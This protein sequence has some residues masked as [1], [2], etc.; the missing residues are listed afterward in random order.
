MGCPFFK[1]IVKPMRQQFLFLFLLCFSLSSAAQ[2]LTLVELNCE[3]LFDTRHDEGKQDAEFLPEAG[4][5][6]TPRRYWR[7]VNNLAQEII[8][9]GDAMQL[10]DVVALCE[11]ENDTCLRDL[12][13][14]SLLRN[15]GYEYLM[16][17]S[18]DERGLD[19]ALLY[20]PASFAPVCYDELHVPT[21][22]GMR[23]TR[24]VLHVAGRIITGDTLH[25]FV[26]HAPSRYG[27]EVASRPFRL[28]VARVLCEAV[29]DLRRHSPDARIVIAGDFNDYFDSPALQQLEQHQLLNVGRQ[30]KGRHGALATY[31]YQGEWRS[32]DHVFVSPSLLAHVAAALI[33]DEPFLL[34]DDERYGGVKPRRTYSGFNYRPA[35]SD[36]L[37]LVVRF[38]F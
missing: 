30:A 16:T 21:L 4:R 28:Q 18:P 29:A 26:V 25:L 22:P 12:T 20:Q 24:D 2:S 15:A 11:V 31:R 10:P 6:W 14:R 8:S 17:C 13:R 36:H 3:N 32:L 37:P 38:R 1:S 9:C 34:E 27:G 23:P 5:H 33:H 35:F 7:K 19:V